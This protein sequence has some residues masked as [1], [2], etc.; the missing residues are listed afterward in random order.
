MIQTEHEE[1][2]MPPGEFG[3]PVIRQNILFLSNPARYGQKIQEKYGDICKT[4]LLGNPAIFVQGKKYLD[5]VLANEGELFE[6]SFPPTFERLLGD[7]ISTQ[8]GDKHKRSRK[9]ISEVFKYKDIEY[10]SGRTRERTLAQLSNWQS[11]K[12]FNLYE[13]IRAFCFDIACEYLLGK[14]D[15]SKHDVFKAYRDFEGG[16]FS[17]PIE[18]PFFKFNNAIKARSY[19]HSYIDSIIPELRNNQKSAIYQLLNSELSRDEIKDQILVLI[20]A[21]HG[22]LA[23]AIWSLIYHLSKNQDVKQRCFDLIQ[24]EVKDS[25]ICEKYISAIALETLRISSPVVGLFRKVI[26]THTFN[27]YIFPE[28]WTISL[29]IRETHLSPNLYPEPNKFNPSRY[30]SKTERNKNYAFG[31]GPRECIGKMLALEEIKI[32]IKELVRNYEWQFEDIHNVK[33][34]RLPVISPKENYK[35]SFYKI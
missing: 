27:G 18:L 3:I 16:L 14:K 22:T 1:G 8:L 4:H 15:L 17:I 34:K 11:K 26:K 20:F 13:D 6:S 24:N 5:H 30:L 31:A 21:G 35:V 32:F 12:N 23:S 2:K 28:S 33:V 7:S 29:Q 10:F 9:I 25:I 19:I